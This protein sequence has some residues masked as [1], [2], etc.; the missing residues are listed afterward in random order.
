MDSSPS[1]SS[2]VTLI[3]S[4]STETYAGRGCIVGFFVFSA[5][6]ELGIPVFSVGGIVV[7]IAVGFRV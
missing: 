6:L 5:G 1:V 4:G 2:T 3:K 7:V